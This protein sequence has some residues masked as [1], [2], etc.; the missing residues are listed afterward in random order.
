MSK[1]PKNKNLIKLENWSIINYSGCIFN[2]MEFEKG[3]W[4]ICVTLFLTEEES[5]ILPIEGIYSSYKDGFNIV[6]FLHK[7]FLK[8]IEE[9]V[10]I[11][12]E[13]ELVESIKLFELDSSIENMTLN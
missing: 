10:V 5:L 3:S 9:V 13:G 7:Y 12:I 11:D 6:V 1:S 4:Q 2:I 8:A